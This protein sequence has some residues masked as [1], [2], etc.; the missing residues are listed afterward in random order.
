MWTWS[1]EHGLRC[2]F[3]FRRPCSRMFFASAYA[4][5]PTPASAKK[6]TPPRPVKSVKDIHADCGLFPNF[7]LQITI[8]LVVFTKNLE[9]EFNESYSFDIF[10]I[11]HISHG[12]SQFHGSRLTRH[13][14]G[15]TTMERRMN[16]DTSIPIHSP[17]SVAWSR[18]R[19]AFLEAI[20][21]GLCLFGFPGACDAQKGHYLSGCQ[22]V[23]F[24]GLHW[25]VLKNPFTCV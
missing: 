23:S 2:V 3:F 16:H 6:P 14:C 10:Q 8:F 5:K 7:K 12:F 24:N 1:M 11:Y 4:T 25:P 17:I 22:G 18:P 21:L 13:C 19:L 15:S 9:I 20:G